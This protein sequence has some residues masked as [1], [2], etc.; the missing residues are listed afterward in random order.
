MFQIVRVELDRSGHVVART[1]LQPL[2]DLRDDAMA[3]AE[4]DASRCDGD[5]GYDEQFD[6]WWGCEQERIYQF[7]IEKVAGLETP[8]AGARDE[9]GHDDRLGAGQ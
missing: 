8:F 1:P 2:Y 5:F 3:L 7:V 6:G 4:F 9:S